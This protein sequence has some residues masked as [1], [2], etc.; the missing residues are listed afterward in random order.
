[1]HLILVPAILTL[2]VT[3]LRLVGA[4]GLAVRIP[5]FS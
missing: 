3:L 2:A 5:W 1:M 4:Y